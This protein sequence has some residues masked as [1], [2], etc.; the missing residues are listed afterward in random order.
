MILTGRCIATAKTLPANSLSAAL[1]YGH[2]VLSN[3]Y[4]KYIFTWNRIVTVERNIRNVVVNG[5]QLKG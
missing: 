3:Y 1:E 5:V 4:D 2:E